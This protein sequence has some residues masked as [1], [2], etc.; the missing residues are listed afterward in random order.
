MLENPDFRTGVTGWTA[1]TNATHDFA[2]SDG[3]GNG[4]SGSLAITNTL[5]STGGGSVMAG[6][7][8]CITMNSATYTFRAQVTTAP[9]SS[10]VFAGSSI[11]YFAM[12]NCTGTTAANFLSQLVPA[13]ES[14]WKTISGI[15]APLQGTQSA[16]VRL[17]MLKPVSDPATTARFDNILL[18]AN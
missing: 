16:M 15:V 6:S 4:S 17:I 7:K 2:T 11:Q 12:P 5:V 18:R 9:G 3:D 8:Q 1:E 14:S 10:G 13:G